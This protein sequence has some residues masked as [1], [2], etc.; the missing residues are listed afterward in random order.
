MR[1]RLQS[2]WDLSYNIGIHTDASSLLAS[3]SIGRAVERTAASHPTRPFATVVVKDSFGVLKNYG[4]SSVLCPRVATLRI[5]RWRH[6]AADLS[7]EVSALAWFALSL[8]PTAPTTTITTR[9]KGFLHEPACF[10]TTCLVVIALCSRSG[11]MTKQ[12][13]G[14]PNV[15]RI[16]D[17]DAGGSAIP[18]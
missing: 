4:L 16:V 15:C 18:K 14:D 3:L 5:C 9:Q 8:G 10:H 11:A 12:A 7:R 17:C 1:S 2:A 13:G 6:E